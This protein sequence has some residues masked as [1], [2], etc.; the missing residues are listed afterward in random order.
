M[1][2]E[3]LYVSS[4]CFL[5]LNPNF[6]FLIFWAQ[7]SLLGVPKVKKIFS[8]E[9]NWPK[10]PQKHPL[11]YD[12][13]EICMFFLQSAKIVIKNFLTQAR[14]TRFSENW[15]IQNR[16]FILLELIFWPKIILRIWFWELFLKFFIDCYQSIFQICL[17]MKKIF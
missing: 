8:I 2:P 7:G 4:W 11:I 3:S 13:T 10:S 5:T 1:Y 6:P 9:P 15:R 16:Y 17:Q 12:K 14:I